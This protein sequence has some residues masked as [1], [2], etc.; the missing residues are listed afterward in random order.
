MRFRKNSFIYLYFLGLVFS[1]L[2]ACIVY[3]GIKVRTILILNNV[4]HLKTELIKERL[5]AQEHMINLY[6][7]HLSHSQSS[8]VPGLVH[9]NL[10]NGNTPYLLARYWIEV[11]AGNQAQ[12]KLALKTIFKNDDRLSKGQL[13]KL[14]NIVLAN[15]DKVYAQSSNTQSPPL[16]TYEEMVNDAGEK[17]PL[18]LVFKNIPDPMS[19]KDNK[20]RILVHAIDFKNM[21]QLLPENTAG[22]Y[23]LMSWLRKY[24]FDTSPSKEYL[25]QDQTVMSIIHI[26]NLGSVRM[27]NLGPLDKRIHVQS[28]LEEDDS[29]ISNVISF[30]GLQLKL[31]IYRILKLTP[32]DFGIAV[33]LIC[34][35]ILLMFI[36]MVRRGI[37]LQK[38]IV[39]EENLRLIQQEKDSL[40]NILAHELRTPLNGIIGMMGFLLKTDLSAEQKYYASAVS[41]SGQIMNLIVDQTLTNTHMQFKKTDLMLEPMTLNELANEL[42]DTLGALAQIKKINLFYE[43]PLELNGVTLMTDKLRLRQILINLIGNSIKFTERGLVKFQF[44]LLPNNSDSTKPI[45]QFDIYDTGIGIDKAKRD[46]IFKQYGRIKDESFKQY[47]VGGLG[48]NISQQLVRLLGGE[49]RFESEYAI[50]SHFYFSIPMTK[51]EQ[52]EQASQVKEFNLK[53]IIFLA[54]KNQGQLDELKALLEAQGAHVDVYDQFIEIRKYFLSLKRKIN[55]PD[56]IFIEENVCEVKGLNYFTDIQEW[57]NLDLSSRVIYLHTSTDSLHRTQV[58]AKGI[59]LAELVPFRPIYLSKQA[60]HFLDI[61]N[62]VSIKR[63]KQSKGGLQGTIFDKQ[64]NVLIADDHQLNAQIMF[65]MIESLGYIASIASN[66]N[67]VL[68]MLEDDHFDCILMDINMPILNGI[69]TTQKIRSSNQSYKNIP[70]IAMSANISHQYENLCLESGMDGYLTKPVE[71][72]VLDKKIME[73]LSKN[74]LS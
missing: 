44:S 45:I 28:T 8:K 69:E 64:L 12:N 51:S 22:G 40:I 71:I 30:N 5:M 11:P 47:S 21:S 63:L 16:F 18:L 70:I 53:H 33:F 32:L 58:F 17:E 4:L 43:I 50:G 2:I 24:D 57:S 67:E 14:E 65:M 68:N 3:E 6:A 48:L 31:N 54:Q 46:E 42:L 39:E 27:D 55:P 52:V 72:A 29:Y 19:A 13:V 61:N 41:Q 1:S 35:A 34:N 26:P 66:G 56:L 73:I 49:I 37:Q 25:D 15:F 20:S 62:Q 7:E 59:K 74:Q 60:L 9:E 36:F 38:K 10:A 23:P